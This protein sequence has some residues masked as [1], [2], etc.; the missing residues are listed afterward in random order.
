MTFREKSGRRKRFLHHFE[1]DKRLRRVVR[2]TSESVSMNGKDRCCFVSIKKKSQR[3]FVSE[4]GCSQSKLIQN[5][6]GMS[7]FE[8]EH[9]KYGKNP[10]QSKL[11]LY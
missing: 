4:A 10:I 2:V 7:H 11:M 3:V 1:Q 8:Y 6:I 5:F 9:L